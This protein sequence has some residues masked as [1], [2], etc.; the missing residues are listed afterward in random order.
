MTTS[1]ILSGRERT[2]LFGGLGNSDPGRVVL[3][4]S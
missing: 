1:P 4:L 2:S 3:K